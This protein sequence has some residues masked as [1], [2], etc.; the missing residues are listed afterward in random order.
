MRVRRTYCHS[1]RQINHYANRGVDT[2]MDTSLSCDHLH[3]SR[4]LSFLIQTSTLQ[5]KK[6]GEHLHY[7]KYF[8]ELATGNLVTLY[9]LIT[10]LLAEGGKLH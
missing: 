8:C 6:R 4:P 1:P 3:L 7:T 5:K 2:F 10:K 9:Y